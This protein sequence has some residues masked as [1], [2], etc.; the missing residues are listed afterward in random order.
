MRAGTAPRGGGRGGEAGLGEHEL[1]GGEHLGVLAPQVPQL[2]D[3]V[4]AKVS[5][6]PHLNVPLDV[7][8][9]VA[10]HLLHSAQ[11][12][13]QLGCLHGHVRTCVILVSLRV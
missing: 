12:F 3:H 10:T 1:H 5:H 7:L 9:G 8:G 13:N 2:L 11:L 6:L 4:G